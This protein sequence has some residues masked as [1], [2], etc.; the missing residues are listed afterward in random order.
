MK[1]EIVFSISINNSSQ[2]NDTATFSRSLV[3]QSSWGVLNPQI[4]SREIQT[5]LRNALFN[6]VPFPLSFLVGWLPF[7]IQLKLVEGNPDEVVSARTA[8]FTKHTL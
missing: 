3:S 5:K 4:Y 8:L 7:D 6:E 2:R 1:I